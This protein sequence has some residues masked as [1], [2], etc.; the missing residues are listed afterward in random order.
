MESS[1]VFGAYVQIDYCY[2]MINELKRRME[3]PL[4]PLEKMIDV[5]TGYGKAKTQEDIKTCINLLQTIIENKKIIEA[6]YSYD[7]EMIDGL[8]ELSKKLK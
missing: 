3:I 6:D 7:Q 2:Y 5:A 8:S 4:S 1:E